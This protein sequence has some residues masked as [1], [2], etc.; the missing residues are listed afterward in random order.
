MSEIYLK[1]IQ[2]VQK[3]L[4][5]GRGAVRQLMSDGMPRIKINNRTVLFRTADIDD[6]LNKY[7]KSYQNDLLKRIIG[8]M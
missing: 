3:Y 7:K 2:E 6:F 4:G 1:G 5:C 8:E